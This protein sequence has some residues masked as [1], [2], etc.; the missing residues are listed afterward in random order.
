MPQHITKGETAQQ[1]RFLTNYIK[2]ENNTALTSKDG[3]ITE[4]PGDRRGTKIQ[5]LAV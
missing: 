1:H 4:Y 3:N 2:I 5:T